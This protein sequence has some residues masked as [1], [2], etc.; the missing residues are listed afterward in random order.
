VSSTIY[1]VMK[2]GPPERAPRAIHDFHAMVCDLI[3]LRTFGGSLDDRAHA[4]RVFEAHNQ[5]V[6]DAIP[7]SRLLVYR[8]GDGWEPLCRFLGVPVPDEAFPHLNDTAWYRVRMG[9]V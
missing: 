1:P 5:A 3:A 2:Q 7:A 8:A 4:T 9:L 6:I